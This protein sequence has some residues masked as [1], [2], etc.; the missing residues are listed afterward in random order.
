MEFKEILLV[1]LLGVFAVLGIIS[2]ILNAKNDAKH[3][4]DVRVVGEKLVR[5]IDLDDIEVGKP[6]FA[7]EFTLSNMR[8]LHRRKQYK[9]LKNLLKP[10][11]KAFETLL[12]KI[13]FSN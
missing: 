11:V 9:E 8:K 12:K 5:K 6:E 10:L 7:H 4:A 1:I 3:D 13:T 2:F